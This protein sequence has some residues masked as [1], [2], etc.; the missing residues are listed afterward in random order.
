MIFASLPFPEIDPVLFRIGPFVLDFLGGFQLGPLEIRWYA[1]SYIAGLM[2]AWIYTKRLV[3]NP[4]LWAGQAPAT[5]VHIDDL[6]LWGALGV[7][8]GGR[9]GYIL[10]Y[11]FEYYLSNPSAIFAVWSGGMSF[12]GGFAGVILAVLLFCRVRGIPFFPTIDVVATGVPIGLFFG[13]IA[14]FINQELYGRVTDVP[15]G[16]VFPRGGPEPRHPSQLYEAALEGVLLFIVLRICSHRLLR[17]KRPGYISG[18]FAIVYGL[19]RMFVEL[20]R[21]P[22]AHIGF[23]SGGLTMGMLLSVPMVVLGLWLVLR[24]RE[25]TA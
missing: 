3:S 17:L 24:A 7:I 4:R 20:F 23:L 19:S 1:L 10:A 2:F 14:N 9:V 22:D 25:V 13:R 11:N 5:P 16:V 12:H 15:W 21:M 8:L 18:V 6:L